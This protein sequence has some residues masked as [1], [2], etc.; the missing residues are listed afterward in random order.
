VTLPFSMYWQLPILLVVISLVYSATRFDRWDLI[1]REA[2]RW[3]SRMV[4]FLLAI[5]VAMF[6]VAGF[7]DAR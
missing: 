5:G 6:L 2:F 7:I 4:G 3:G 1:L